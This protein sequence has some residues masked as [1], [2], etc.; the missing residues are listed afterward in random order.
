MHSFALINVISWCSYIILRN[1]STF[2]KVLLTLEY[3]RNL[4]ATPHCCF[5]Q[6][7]RGDY[8]T[9][10]SSIDQWKVNKERKYTLITRSNFKKSK[11]KPSLEMNKLIVQAVYNKMHIIPSSFTCFSCVFFLHSSSPHVRRIT[12]NNEKFKIQLNCDFDTFRISQAILNVREKKTTAPKRGKWKAIWITE[13]LNVK[14]N[15]R[16]SRAI[17]DRRSSFF[18]FFFHAIRLFHRFKNHLRREKK[19]KHA[20]DTRI[21]TADWRLSDK[22]FLIGLI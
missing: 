13:R 6:E 19:E 9:I 22:L 18:F 16:Q 17:R 20:H 12:A 3:C 8:R 11:Y 15:S 14:K 5:K 21:T 2:I 1:D 4:S 7:F 10:S